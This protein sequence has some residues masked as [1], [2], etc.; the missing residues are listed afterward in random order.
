MTLEQCAQAYGLPAG[1]ALTSGSS[2]PPLATSTATGPTPASSGSGGSGGGG[3]NTTPPPAVPTT[4]TA[5]ASEPTSSGAGSGAGSTPSATPSASQILVETSADIGHVDQSSCTTFTSA[6][7]ETINIPDTTTP[8]LTAGPQPSGS[9]T[10]TILIPVPTV[11]P[12]SSTIGVPTPS[13]TVPIAAGHRV[14]GGSAGLVA[15]IAAAIAVAD[16]W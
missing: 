9:G 11:R 1:G 15:C 13:S 6:I 14:V 7:V 12:S 3:G 4:A 16:L 8:L 5:E 10:S 2:A